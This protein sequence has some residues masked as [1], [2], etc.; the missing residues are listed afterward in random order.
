LIPNVVGDFGHFQLV[1]PGLLHEASDEPQVSCIQTCCLQ[2][3]LEPACGE[4]NP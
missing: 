4:F 3:L 2:N 1:S